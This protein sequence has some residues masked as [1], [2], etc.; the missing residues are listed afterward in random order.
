MRWR[1][2]PGAP[3]RP[4]DAGAVRS[5]LRWSARV[6]T[7]AVSFDPG[8]VADAVLNTHAVDI[9]MGLLSV[10][11]FRRRDD[12]VRIRPAAGATGRWCTGPLRPRAFVVETAVGPIGPG[13]AGE[14]ARIVALTALA[15]GL[16]RDLREAA[17]PVPE[18]ML[19]A[20]ADGLALASVH[21]A[22]WRAAL[23]AQSD[24]VAR[25]LR[26]RPDASASPPHAFV[27]MHLEGATVE[28][29]SMPGRACVFRTA[30]HDPP[31]LRVYVAL[32]DAAEPPLHEVTH[33]LLQMMLASATDD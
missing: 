23:E 13:G 26:A 3:M 25:R 30:R 19:C 2:M 31:F 27:A 16:E 6:W 22:P 4:R 15:W 10:R 14:L 11:G 1:V 21:P 18:L 9:L 28:P 29:W 17:H 8:T 33:G 7:L 24:A 5:T 32:R 20:T 12:A